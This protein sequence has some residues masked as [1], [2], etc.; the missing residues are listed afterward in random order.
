[1]RDIGIGVAIAALVLGGF[2]VVKLFILDKHDEASSATTPSTIAT[3]KLS[4]PPGVT[5]EMFVDDKKT[6][7]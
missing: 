4:M 7:P 6:R 3:V 1:M 5:A 2:F